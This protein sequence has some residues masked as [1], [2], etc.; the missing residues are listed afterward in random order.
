MIKHF[1]IIDDN[2]PK[3]QLWH[4]RPV[5]GEGKDQIKPLFERKLTSQEAAL[6]DAGYINLSY[7]VERFQ[8]A[9]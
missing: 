9:A 2:G 8:N 4:E 7:F 6:V 3:P 1:V 5:T